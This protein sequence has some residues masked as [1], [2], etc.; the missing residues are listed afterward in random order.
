[1]RAFLV[2]VLVA[3]AAGPAVAQSAQQAPVRRLLT[4][5][6]DSAG[7]IRRATAEEIRQLHVEFEALMAQMRRAQEQLARDSRD[8]RDRREFMQAQTE[9]ARMATA[10]FPKQSQLTLA[11]ATLR[12]VTNGREGYL[13]VTFG[14]T[15]KVTT[16]QSGMQVITTAE[17]PPRID[18]VDLGSPADRAGVRPGDEWLAIAGKPVFDFAEH[19]LDLLLKPGAR[20]TLRLRADGKEREATV[21]VAK[22]PEFPTKECESAGGFAIAAPLPEFYVGRINAAPPPDRAPAVAP[23]PVDVPRS[24]MSVFFDNRVMVPLYGAVFRTLDPDARE[25][26]KIEVEGVLVDQVGP[27]TPAGVAG[28]RRY[29][30]VTHVNGTA[31]KSPV[32]VLQISNDARTLTLTVVRSGETRTVTLTRP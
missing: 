30:V 7:F 17:G 3:T 21:V 28:L 10:V 15:L 27:T 31:I 24:G 23:R 6:I 29:D 1:M 2:S 16:P 13:G 18:A 20:V 26:M 9:F 11:C 19:D 14:R 4:A 25:V 12:A 8:G 32:H 22:R 5:E